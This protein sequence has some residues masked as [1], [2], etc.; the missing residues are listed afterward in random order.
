VSAAPAAWAFAPVLG[1]PLAHAPVLRFDLAPRLRRPIARGLFGEN[2]TWRGAIV[3]T[4]G[5]M[6]A[7]V[8]L[9]R[10]P[11]YRL[12]LPR[13]VADADP[14]MVGC[15]LGSAS[16]LGELPNSFVKRRLGIPPGAQRASALGVLI[17]VYDQADWVPVA[18]LLLRPIW[19]MS[20]RE[21]AQVFA[22]V[23][24]I[25]VPINLLGYVLGA[26]TAP[27]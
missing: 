7:S 11:A 18:W 20:P 26:R 12:R 1:G 21:M 22:L 17:S 24:A 10:V 9:A 6:L 13:A 14:V 2:K 19:R 4:A 15:L 27:L 5:T 3:M 16:W 23:A 25:H 8:A